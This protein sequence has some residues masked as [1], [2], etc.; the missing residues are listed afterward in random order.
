MS[1]HVKIRDMKIVEKSLLRVYNKKALCE[2]I[3]RGKLMKMSKKI[4]GKAIINNEEME[5]LTEN[6]NM[7]LEYYITKNKPKDKNT[8]K[9]YG[10]EVVK[11]TNA[12]TRPEKEEFNNIF[13]CKKEANDVLKLLVAN[14]VTPIGLGD[15]LENFVKIY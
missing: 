2:K 10:V 15:V 9:Q 1:K 7:L 12:E 3:R 6:E 4:Y 14:K 13:N 8:T 11:L 5:E